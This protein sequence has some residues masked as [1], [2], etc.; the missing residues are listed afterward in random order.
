MF[1]M[2]G[3][4]KKMPKD[5]RANVATMHSAPGCKHCRVSA[6]LLERKLNYD[7]A[8]H[9]CCVEVSSQ[10]DDHWEPFLN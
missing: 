6:M 5:G 4:K 7:D 2:L 3:L 9:A 1:I 10:E 8:E